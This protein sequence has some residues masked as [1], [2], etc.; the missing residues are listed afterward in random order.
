MKK[1]N[2]DS[3][4]TKYQTKQ[5]L[6]VTVGFHAMIWNSLFSLISKTL[7]ILNN[8]NIFTYKLVTLI[9]IDYTCTYYNTL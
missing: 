4:M 3:V 8:F 9:C 5:L 7:V 6:I 1:K 2:V